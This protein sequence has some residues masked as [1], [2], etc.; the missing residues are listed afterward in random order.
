VDS[1]QVPSSIILKA[2]WGISFSKEASRGCTWKG[3][4]P[5]IN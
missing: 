2:Y 3:L 4:R 1:D 5:A